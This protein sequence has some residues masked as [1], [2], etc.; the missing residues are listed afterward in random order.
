MGKG[1]YKFF[2]AVLTLVIQEQELGEGPIKWVQCPNP[3]GTIGPASCMLIR[4]HA[5]CALSVA[6]FT[7]GS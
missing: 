2:S 1:G 6:N 5:R 4:T 7:L 3:A